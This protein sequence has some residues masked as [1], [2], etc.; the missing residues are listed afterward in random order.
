MLDHALSREGSAV[1]DEDLHASLSKPPVNLLF[2]PTLASRRGVWSISISYLLERFL[3][4]LEGMKSKDLRLCGVAA[5]SSALI[6][7]LKVESI[8]LLEKIANQRRQESR[9]SIDIS[10]MNLSMPYRHEVAYDLSLED[11][12]EMLSSIVE[13]I[14]MSSKQGAMDAATGIS[15]EPLDTSTH[16]DSYLITLEGIIEDYKSRLYTLVMERGSTSL[17]DL[18]LDLEPIEVARYFI[19]LLH[20][21]MDGRVDIS[22]SENGDVS[23]TVRRPTGQ[24]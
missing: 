14:Y 4:I 3:S 6:F 2:N 17:N 11:L 22:E 16:G 18:T 23:I 19:A 15:I 24:M 5:L 13:R 9:E 10:S 8:F 7:R 20:L 12:L 21:C 1:S